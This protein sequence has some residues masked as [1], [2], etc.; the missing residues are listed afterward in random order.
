MLPIRAFVLQSFV[1]LS[2]T[3]CTVG[4]GGGPAAAGADANSA[5]ACTEYCTLAQ[6][7][8]TEANA[9]YADQ[10][11][12][13]AAC[14]KLSVAGVTGDADGDTVQCR[15]YHLGAAKDDPATHCEHAGEDGGGVCIQGENVS[16]N[17]VT[18]QIGGFY[19]P[20][21]MVAVWVEASDGAFVKTIG[22]WAETNK[23]DLVSW[24]AA[25]GANDTDAVSGATRATHDG[26][27]TADFDLAG[28]PDGTF[29]IRV[30][31]SDDKTPVPAD[32][33]QATFTFNKNGTT[34]TQNIAAQDGL[35][36]I[37][38]DYSGR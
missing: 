18:T 4:G 30:E 34:D 26:T 10:T 6:A 22:R 27:L 32:S 15:I 23:T 9:L 2:L 29:T 38:I 33:H 5:A 24:I 21:N 19:A 12:C 28:I 13:E 16:I 3:G 36:N 7:N 25:A 1:L 35:T 14:A 37:K 31:V 8:C 17:F 11:A 20:K